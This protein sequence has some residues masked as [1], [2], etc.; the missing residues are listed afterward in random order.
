MDLEELGI[1][2]GRLCETIVTTFHENGTPNAAPMGVTGEGHDTVV[3]RVHKATDTYENLL[4]ENCCVLNVVFDPILFLTCA[5]L[6]KH[7][8][9]K[10]VESK[11]TGRA[12][13]VNAPFLK[14]AHAYLETKVKDVEEFNSTDHLGNSKGAVITLKIVDGCILHPFPQT[15]NRGFFSAIELAISLSRGNKDDVK[16]HLQVIKKCLSEEE[17]ERIKEFV[18]SFTV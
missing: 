8:G 9:S 4:R 6:G 17:S 12:G 3:L 14:T 15:P 7:K 11:M 2:K 5:L 16:N 1:K 10:V 18:D 13:K